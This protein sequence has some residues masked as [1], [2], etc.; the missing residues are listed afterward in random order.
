RQ[1]FLRYLGEVADAVSG[2]NKADRTKLYG[3]LLEVAKKRTV[4][5]DVQLDDRGRPV[6]EDEDDFGEN[7]LIVDP[8]AEVAAGNGE[9]AN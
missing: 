5:A 1:I 9:I 4:E 7:V 3:R 8:E 6:D 2:I